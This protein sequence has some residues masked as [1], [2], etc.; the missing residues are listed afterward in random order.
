[1]RSE[2][3]DAIRNGTKTVD[4]R[5]VADDIA[6]LRTGQMVHY[7]GARVRV[8]RI[9]YYPGFR[10]L[11]QHEDWRKIAPTITDSDALLQLLESGHEATI[12]SSGAVAIEIERVA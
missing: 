3:E 2:W 1:M 5:L 4:A 10:D 12:A 8:R 9:R 11:L 7:P 6:D